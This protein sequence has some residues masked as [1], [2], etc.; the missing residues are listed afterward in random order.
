[1]LNPIKSGWKPRGLRPDSRFMTIY[2]IDITRYFIVKSL[3]F[4]A[5]VSTFRTSEFV[6]LTM[7]YLN[8]QFPL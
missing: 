1:M 7:T 3:T 5:D 8:P 4:M 6:E 2:L